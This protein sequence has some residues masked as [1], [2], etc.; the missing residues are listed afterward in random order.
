MVCQVKII[1]DSQEIKDQ[2]KT[3]TTITDNKEEID[4]DS[5]RDNNHK[6]IEE[7]HK[8]MEINKKLHHHNQSKKLKSFN[9]LLL[10]I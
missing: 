7:D 3:I 1:I 4:Q 2:D 5:H 6:I 8:I 10:K 9:K